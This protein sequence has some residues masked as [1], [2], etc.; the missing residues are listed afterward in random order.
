L[1]K[2]YTFFVAQV[3]TFFSLSVSLLANSMDPDQTA[4]MR[5]L[6]WIHAGC[7]PIMLVLSWRGSYI[8]HDAYI[9]FGEKVCTCVFLAQMLHKIRE[10][11]FFMIKI[12]TFSFYKWY[13]FYGTTDVL[14]PCH[15]KYVSLFYKWYT[16]K[17]FWSFSCHFMT[18]LHYHLHMEFK[19]VWHGLCNF[20]YLC[21]IW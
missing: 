4:R 15:K 10:F 19:I 7:K 2:R 16:F 14:K 17:K 1:Y 12:N 5:R 21:I 6:V 20:F 11:L 9:F 8:V 13:D 18:P 3:Y